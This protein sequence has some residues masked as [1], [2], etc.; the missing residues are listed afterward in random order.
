MGVPHVLNHADIMATICFTVCVCY[1]R[2][3]QSSLLIVQL[4]YLKEGLRNYL[5]NSHMKHQE[6]LIA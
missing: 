1:L 2:S 5:V 6:L 3:G 4:V